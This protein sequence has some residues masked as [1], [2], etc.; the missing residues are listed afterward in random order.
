MESASLDG[1]NSWRGIAHPTLRLLRMGHP[2][3]WPKATATT[4]N[5]N[6]YVF[7]AVVVVCCGE[8]GMRGE[9]AW[10]LGAGQVRVFQIRTV[11]MWECWRTGDQGGG[12]VPN[13]QRRPQAGTRDAQYRFG[14]WVEMWVRSAAELAMKGFG[15]P[16]REDW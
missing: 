5:I 16:R 6:R 14:G 8:V 4:K 15:F 3:L 2:Q 12:R 11:R 13:L 10:L 1:K 7:I 9:T